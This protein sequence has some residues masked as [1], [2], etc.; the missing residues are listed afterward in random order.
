MNWIQTDLKNST[1]EYD[2]EEVHYRVQLKDRY[3]I[4]VASLYRDRAVWTLGQC[5]ITKHLNHDWATTKQP[6]HQHAKERDLIHTLV[7]CSPFWEIHLNQP[8]SCCR[9]LFGVAYCC[10]FCMV[11]MQDIKIHF[12]YIFPYD[13]FYY[14][15]KVV[16]AFFV[17]K[18]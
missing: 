15:I 12:Y 17:V 16:C 6:L 1:L 11:L 8:Y 3:K 5:I 14:I 9:E 2:H 7:N 18:K 4:W 13:I 10:L